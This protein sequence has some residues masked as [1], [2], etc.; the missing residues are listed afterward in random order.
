[1]KQ[2][3][4]TIKQILN[5]SFLSVSIPALILLLVLTC[6]TIS[7]QIHAD[8]SDTEIQ[9]SQVTTH[10]EEV[11]KRSETQLNNLVVP[12]SPFHSFHYSNTQLLSMIMTLRFII[13]EWI[14]RNALPMC[15]VI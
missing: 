15:C 5:I 13:M 2:N 4:K 9:L 3:P 6:Y 7:R 8:Q 1:M 14:T 12:G 10:M 11:L